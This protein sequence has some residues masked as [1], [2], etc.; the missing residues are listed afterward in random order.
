MSAYPTARSTNLPDQKHVLDRARRTS[1]G[2]IEA[3]LKRARVFAPSLA[4]ECVRARIARRSFTQPLVH[5]AA[6]L[7]GAGSAMDVD[8]PQVFIDG[9]E[10]RMYRGEKTYLCA[11]GPVTAMRTKVIA[12]STGRAGG[13]RRWSAGWASSRGTG[14][15]HAARSGRDAVRAPGA[16]RGRGGVGCVGQHGALEELAGPAPEG[17]VCMRWED[18]RPRFEAQVREAAHGRSTGHRVHDGGLARRSDGRR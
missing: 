17:A 10:H 6:T 12:A 1:S 18:E 7:R 11:V 2:R 3:L 13:G 14:R 16:A 5:V 8:L 15:R 4:S 9:H